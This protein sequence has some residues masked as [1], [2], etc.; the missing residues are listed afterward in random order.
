M[1]QIDEAIQTIVVMLQIPRGHLRILA[2][3]KG[4]VAGNLTFTID[5][6]EVDCS[7]ASHGKYSV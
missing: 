7:A 6:I 5:G 2:T 3:S 1:E 4:L